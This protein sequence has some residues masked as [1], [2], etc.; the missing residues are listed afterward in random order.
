MTGAHDNKQNSDERH[1]QVQ[2]AYEILSDDEKRKAYD[3]QR[4]NP[5]ADRM[6]QQQQFQR[7][8]SGGEWQ[9]PFF[10]ESFGASSSRGRPQD[11]FTHPFFSDD[12]FSRPF[13]FGRSSPF[14]SFGWP[15]AGGRDPFDDMMSSQRRMAHDLS[16]MAA[17]FQSQS[18]SSSIP[19]QFPPPPPAQTEQNSGGSRDAYPGNNSNRQPSRPNVPAMWSFM[20]NFN[21]SN[22]E[23]GRWVSESHSESWINGQRQSTHKRRDANVRMF[24]CLGVLPSSFFHLPSSMPCFRARSRAQLTEIAQ[25][26]QGVEHVT[27]TYPDG[28]TRYLVN[29]VEQPL[30]PPGPRSASQPG[31]TNSVHP[32]RPSRNHHH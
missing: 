32:D 13:P 18:Q 16:R 7:Q 15:F 10:P 17:H 2:Q 9:H 20:G 12:T 25:M 3:Y 28:T 4:T 21:N 1:W 11:P 27:H 5:A 26:I 29:G 14:A 31:T 30:P 6:F 24:P 8:N 22:S 19:R 23:G